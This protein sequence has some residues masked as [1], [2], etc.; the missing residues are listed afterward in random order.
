MTARITLAACCLG[1][2]LGGCEPPDEPP[3]TLELGTHTAIEIHVH[4]AHRNH[5]AAR[6]VADAATDVHARTRQPVTAVFHQHD[7]T[8]RAI[9]H[10]LRAA[11]AVGVVA[12]A[13][14]P[15]AHDAAA[16][17]GQARFPFISLPYPTPA[18]DTLAPHEPNHFRLTLT[19]ERLARAA[20]SHF[21]RRQ[22]VRHLTILSDGTA[23][24]DTLGQAFDDAFNSLLPAGPTHRRLGNP[25]DDGHIAALLQDEPDNHLLLIT[26]DAGAARAVLESLRPAHSANPTRPNRLRVLLTDALLNA[27]FLRLP[28]SRR[29][30]FLST[31][32]NPADS[33]PYT[34]NGP[35]PT[36]D[37]PLAAVSFQ[38]Y[39]AAVMILQAILTTRD[40]RPFRTTIDFREATAA[41]DTYEARGVSG[42]LACRNGLC[43]DP[44][45][46]ILFQP[47]LRRLHPQDLIVAYEEPRPSS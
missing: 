27:D 23:T 17:A 2:A 10:S 37:Q 4:A 44:Q 47:T 15:P 29:T 45:V 25:Q 31:V 8:G 30:H 1:L 26:A 14:C 6:A 5:P 33:H 36:A 46:R 32:D 28:A 19:A 13:P 21:I 43:A 18:A 12:I 7:C 40:V 38:A 16:G 41:L 24:A 3:H 20:A 22:G 35:R 34:A 11:T 39:D 9:T 42:A